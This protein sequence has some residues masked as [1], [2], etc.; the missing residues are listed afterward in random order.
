M[1]LF[2]K[3]F[4]IFIICFLFIFATYLVMKEYMHI[5][6]V[7]LIIGDRKTNT[8]QVDDNSE[9]ED[10]DVSRSSSSQETKITVSMP[11]G[12]EKNESSVLEHQYMKGT[13]SF[14]LKSEPFEGTD[15]YDIVDQAKEIYSNTFDNVTYI[16][17]TKDIEINENPAKTIV[18]TADIAGLEMKYMYAYTIINGEVYVATFGDLAST[19]DS[20]Q[21]DYD[22]I[23]A[24]IEY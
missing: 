1:K 22:A 2:S 21:S 20:L 19:F 4:A 14:M 16:G 3:L 9:V 13:S 24:S 12:W 18:F 11:D 10:V 8:N 17:S 5:D 6:L 15:L 23:L 7:K